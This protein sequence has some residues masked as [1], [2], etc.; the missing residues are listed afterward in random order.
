MEGPSRQARSSARNRGTVGCRA[1]ASHRGAAAER[2]CR[3]RIAAVD[4]DGGSMGG[5]LLGRARD[6]TDGPPDI[7]RSDFA[8]SIIIFSRIRTDNHPLNLYLFVL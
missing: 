1:R 3:A 5:A 6:R 7:S 4:E 8:I 2:A